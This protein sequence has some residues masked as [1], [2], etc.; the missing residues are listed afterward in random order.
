[1]PVNYQLG[2]IYRIVNSEN[3]VEYIGSTAQKYLSARMSTHRS[4]SMKKGSPFYNAMREIG[5]EKFQILLIKTFPCGSKAELEAEEYRILD[6]KIAAG[7]EIY[8]DRIGGKLSA[9]A[10]KKIADA[11]TGEKSHRFDFGHVGLY[12]NGK[13]DIWRFKFNE[14]GKDKSKNFSVKKYGFW[15]AKALAEAERKLTYPE[16]KTDEELELAA[17]QSIEL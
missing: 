3:S 4:D 7:V 11:L 14:D 15:G 13:Y 12:A 9:A 5:P 6:E 2:K 17:F 16:W 1:M 10:C 8:N